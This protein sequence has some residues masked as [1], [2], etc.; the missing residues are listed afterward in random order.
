VT[1]SLYFTVTGNITPRLHPSA[2][3]INISDIGSYNNGNAY[4]YQ[5]DAGP[6]PPQLNITPPNT[7]NFGGFVGNFSML[8]VA[9]LIN[10]GATHGYYTFGLYYV[11]DV[12]FYPFTGQNSIGT[13]ILHVVA[14][15]Q[16]LG[17]PVF[18]GINILLIDKS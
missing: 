4:G 9:K 13:H 5:I 15:L 14:S 10:Q 11:S 12:G 17:I 1:V 18:A 16:G 3:L 2:L 8:S 7:K 6:Y